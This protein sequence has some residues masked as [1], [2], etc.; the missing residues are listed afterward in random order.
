[1]QQPREIYHV[2]EILEMIDRINLSVASLS[3]EEFVGDINICDAT[4]LRLEVIGEAAN[5]I[6]S[7]IWEMYDDVD[8]QAIVGL[9][10][11][12][13]HVYRKVD[14]QIIW[15]IITNDMAQLYETLYEYLKINNVNIFNEYVSKSN[16]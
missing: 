2:V 9:R 10:H 12:I 11:I 13:A 5:N 16:K 1:M 14:L 8:W 3:Y 15:K 6:K 7:T 4:I